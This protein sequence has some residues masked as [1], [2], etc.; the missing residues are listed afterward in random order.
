MART[1]WV[2]LITEPASEYHVRIQLERF[3]LHPYIPQCRQRWRLPGGGDLLKLR[4]LLPRIV[5]LPCP[6]A[7]SPALHNIAHLQIL[8]LRIPGAIVSAI[9]LR[10]AQREFDHERPARQCRQA[11]AHRE[12]AQ[13]FSRGFAG[14][15][16]CD[17]DAIQQFVSR[18]AYAAQS[19]GVHA[20]A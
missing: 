20:G 11:S 14:A 1:D 6:E 15:V 9:L 5:L 12:A 19:A 8:P 18:L 13:W 7:N 2:A 3:D 4:P 17:P 16:P 10:E